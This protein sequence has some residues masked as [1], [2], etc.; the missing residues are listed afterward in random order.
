[1]RADEFIQASQN[2]P[3]WEQSIVVAAVAISFLLTL[4]APALGYGLSL[5]MIYISASKVR[6][7]VPITLFIFSHAGA[8]IF[9]SQAFMGVSA[10]F[11]NYFANFKAICMAPSIT[12]VI[13]LYGD[14]IGLP[15]VY[16]IF[17]FLGFCD[18]KIQ[19]L[20]YVQGLVF[21]WAFLFI[22]Y[23]IISDR[24]QTTNLPIVLV[25]LC[26]LFSFFQ[27]TQLARQ[28]VSS[29]FVLYALFLAR[30]PVQIA[31]S[32]LIGT[33]FHASAPLIYI[34]ALVLRNSSALLLPFLALFSFGLYFY[35]SDLVSL[36]V[37][38]DRVSIFSK[39]IYYA[40]YD[41]SDSV[42]S[43]YLSVFYLLLAFSFKYLSN[44]SPSRSV[45]CDFRLALGCAAIGAVLLPLPLAA[46]R[47]LLPF[48]S[49]AAG[50]FLFHGMALWNANFTKLFLVIFTLFRLFSFETSSKNGQHALWASY[51]SLSNVPGYYLERYY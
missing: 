27:A 51:D 17:T 35:I 47:I 18:L 44:K 49:M 11:A 14:E 15:V 4:F 26:V 40:D 50:Y 41:E 16:T 10:D 7:I 23:R 39:F 13:E 38:M 3:T 29:T 45:D 1:M 46:T 24:V 5:L 21:S 22:G 32:V 12:D 9:A 8:V 30:L 31:F 25:G 19:G 34:L 37:E 6:S 28:F 36:A 43:D 20:A 42:K 33:L 48:G 2:G